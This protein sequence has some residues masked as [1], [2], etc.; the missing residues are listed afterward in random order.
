MVCKIKSRWEAAELI[1]DEQFCIKIVKFFSVNSVGEVS[2]ARGCLRVLWNFPGTEA[3][4]AES[5][6]TSF[7]AERIM[8]SQELHILYCCHRTSLHLLHFQKGACHQCLGS[9][10]QLPTQS[11]VGNEWRLLPLSHLSSTES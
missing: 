3:V 8:V 7:L 6:F 11:S 10:Q 1:V 9:D 2:G 4:E 5:G